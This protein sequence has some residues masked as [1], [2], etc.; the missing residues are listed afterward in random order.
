MIIRIFPLTQKRAYE[1]EDLDG[2]GEVP[3]GL[4]SVDL[5]LLH[6]PGLPCGRA[7][8]AVPPGRSAGGVEELQPEVG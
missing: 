1:D 7:R 2:G 8:A 4:F 5:L 3:V 6:Q